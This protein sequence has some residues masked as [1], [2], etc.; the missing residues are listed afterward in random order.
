MELNKKRCPLDMRGGHTLSRR[1]MDCSTLS[2]LSTFRTVQL[3]RFT[4]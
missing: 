4:G 2:S 3:S 1:L